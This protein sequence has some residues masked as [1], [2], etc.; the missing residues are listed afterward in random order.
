E[1]LSIEG[2]AV[3]YQQYFSEGWDI[4]KKYPVGFMG[5]FL[6]SAVLYFFISQSGTYIS[7]MVSVVLSSLFLACNYHMAHYLKKGGIPSFEVFFEPLKDP[8]QLVI[9]ALLS[10][11]LVGIGFVFLIIPGLYLVVSWVFAIPIIVFTKTEFWPAMEYSRKVITRQWFQIFGFLVL[12]FFVILLGAL[13]L[14]IGI[15]VAMPVVYC[16]LYAAFSDIFGLRTQEGNPESNNNWPDEDSDI[17][18]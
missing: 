14:G 12:C 3:R 15:I 2:Y 6:I 10:S 11:L 18:Y 9:Y 4:F 5:L 8:L 16:S 1:K 17:T 7:N 13:A